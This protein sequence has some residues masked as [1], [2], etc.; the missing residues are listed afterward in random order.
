MGRGRPN[1]RTGRAQGQRAWWILA[2]VLLA[3]AAVIVR[4]YAPLGPAGLDVYFVRYDNVRHIGSLVAVRRPGP[5]RRDA[6]L[7]TRLTWALQ[8][9]LAGPSAEERRQGIVSEIPHGT[10]LRGVRIENGVVLVDLT[11]TFAQGGGSTSMLARVWQIVYTATQF[12]QA[13]SVQILLDGRRIEALG[14]EGVSIGS[15]LRRL[16]TPPT[17]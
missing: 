14:G 5:G 10:T 7:T 3:A 9:L 16:A 2:L 15:P 1:R 8:P 13:P 12:S 4:W 17:F 6:R 11:G